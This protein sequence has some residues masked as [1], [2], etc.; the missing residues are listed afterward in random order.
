MNPWMEQMRSSVALFQR[1]VD[2]S[3]RRL[4]TL[5]ACFGIGPSSSAL[6]S[7]PPDGPDPEGDPDTASPEQIGTRVV[8]LPRDPQWAFVY[9]R[10]DTSDCQRALAWGARDLCLRVADVTG[11]IGGA[12][13]PHTL[14]EIVVE[15]NATEWYLPVPVSD[16]EYRV[17]LGYR[18][19]VPGGWI[20]LA[21]SSVARMPALHP[22]ER[23]LDRYEPFTMAGGEPVPQGSDGR[24]TGDG[25]HERLYQRGA[26]PWRGLSKGSEAFHAPGPPFQGAGGHQASGAGIWSSGRGDSGNGEVPRR[27]RPFWLMVDAELIVYGG[28]DPA[29]RLTIHGDPVPLS[30][31][32]TFRLE[33]SFPDGRQDYPIQAVA[34]DGLQR[35]SFLMEFQRRT[36]L[37]NGNERSEAKTEGTE[38]GTP[39]WF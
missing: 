2:F 16:R 20:S 3:G 26:A 30:A 1:L 5:T 10:I 33:R 23:I 11:L 17:E 18:T 27:W 22:S 12:A 31:D 25:L 36:H 9:W 13:H 37:A 32:G 19:D 34:S 4:S 7:A 15:S 29:A 35:R 24:S 6:D 14:Q 28:T 39:E 8:F 21:F 38:E